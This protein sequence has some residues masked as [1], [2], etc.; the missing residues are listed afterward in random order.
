VPS[1]DVV[2]KINLAEVDNAVNQAVK[3]ISQR[4]DFRGSNSS[5]KREEMVITLESTDDHKVKAEVDVLQGKLV[6]RGVSLKVLKAGTIEP[7]PGGRARQKIDLQQGIDQ[8]RAREVVKALKA[9]KLKVQCAIQ[10]DELR[11]SGKH[12]DDLQEAIALIKGL[13][14]P[15]PLQ[16][17][18]FRD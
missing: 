6:K 13:E 15:L 11:V 2:S 1:F 9:S 5:V 8:G 3:E 18:N 12:K 14:L 4:F 10:G 7:A 17:I 16:F